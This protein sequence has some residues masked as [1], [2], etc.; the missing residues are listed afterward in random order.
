MSL[1]KTSILLVFIPSLTAFAQAQG[2]AACGAACDT[3]NT[4]LENTASISTT[5]VENPFQPITAGDVFQMCGDFSEYNGDGS[6][7][8]CYECGGFGGTVAQEELLADWA[9]VCAT[10][11]ENG[12][13]ANGKAA[14]AACWN[15]GLL[16]SDCGSL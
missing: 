8:V 3:Y 5:D 2:G 13:N 1:S 4:N 16:Q 9:L 15:S 12:A 11:I 7:Y 6:A 14:G 10:Y